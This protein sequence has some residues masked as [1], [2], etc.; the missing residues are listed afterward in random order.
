MYLECHEF[1]SIPPTV[2]EYKAVGIIMLDAGIKGWITYGS[3]YWE[4]Y[5]LLK[6][7]HTCR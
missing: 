1:S 2:P 6:G 4:T 7:D 5:K 3:C